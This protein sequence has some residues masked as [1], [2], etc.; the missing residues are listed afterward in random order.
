MAPSE[1]NIVLITRF[2]PPDTGGG[3]IAAYASYMAKGLKAAGHQVRV[4]S[5]MGAQSRHRTIVDG[6]EVYRI[7]PLAIPYRYHRIPVVGRYL[8]FINDILYAWEVRQQLLRV[9][10]EQRPDI[11]EY[12]DIDAEAIFHPS[13][14]CPAVVKLHTPHF[15]LRPF[16]AERE[17]PYDTNSVAWIEKKAVRKASGISSPSRSLAEIVALE[18][19]LPSTYCEYVPNPIDT[20]SFSPSP[21]LDQGDTVLYV[22]RLERLKGADTFAQAIPVVAPQ[23]PH[24]KFVFL[25]ADRYGPDGTSQQAALETFLRKRGL[26]DKVKFQGHAPPE[27]FL[28]SYRQAAIV[29]VPSRYENCPYTLLEAMACG[30]PIV[31]SRAYGMEEMLVDGESGLFFRPGDATDL[32]EKISRLLESKSLR[33]HLGAGARRAALERYALPVATELTISF[34]HSVLSSST[35]DAAVGSNRSLSWTRS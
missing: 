16:Y 34:Y 24:S 3:G 12:A 31:V 2:Y 35:K 33:Q 21:A 10:K 7:K 23:F 4:I 29:V 14:L 9:A 11:A 6:I 18:Y 28:D 26:T 15:V 1:M 30:K 25:G 32:A 20:E 27:V 19:N 8:R 5:A 17:L 13:H 22:G